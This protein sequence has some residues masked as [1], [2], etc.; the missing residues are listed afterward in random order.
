MNK[1]MIS[2][3]ND[4]IR[5]WVHSYWES[6]NTVKPRNFRSTF[7][8]QMLFATA[9]VGGHYTVQGHSMSLILVAIESPHAI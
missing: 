1:I 8:W 9:R 2:T 5:S 7:V 6:A 4:T 3:K